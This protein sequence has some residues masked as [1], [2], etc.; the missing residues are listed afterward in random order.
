MEQNVRK[1]KNG[2]IMTEWKCDKCKRWFINNTKVGKPC[3]YGCG[4]KVIELN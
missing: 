4:G 1:Q 3:P 2:E